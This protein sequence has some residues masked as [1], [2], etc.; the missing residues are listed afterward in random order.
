MGFLTGA[1]DARTRFADG[2]IRKIES[3]F[4]PENL[5][6]NLA[7]VAL[8]QRWATQKNATP[9][10]I[11]LAWLMDHKPWIVP[12]PGTTQMVHL[13]E[14]LGADTIRF[15]PA[16]RAELNIAVAAIKVQG[17]RLPDSVLVYSDVEALAK[18]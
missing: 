7:L 13:L 8:L 17:A 15:T 10:Q 14:N 1:I 3:R 6:R 16:E 18:R 2:D 4:A 9:A 11:T 5:P 12:I